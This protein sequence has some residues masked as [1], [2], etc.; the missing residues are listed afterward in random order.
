MSYTY[1]YFTNEKLS[2]GRVRPKDWMY[3]V[4][5]WIATFDNGRLIYNNLMS[6]CEIKGRCC[7]RVDMDQLLKQYPNI[8]T[9]LQIIVKGLEAK[10]YADLSD[11]QQGPCYRP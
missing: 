4:S 3:R 11:M 10:H 8:Y 7:L 6:P 9:E 2:G 1:E 5:C